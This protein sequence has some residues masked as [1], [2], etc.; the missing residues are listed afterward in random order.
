MLHNEVAD[1]GTDATNDIYFLT[2]NHTEPGPLQQWIV[3]PDPLTDEE[4]AN[5]LAEVEHAMR[6]RLRMID[7]IPL[8]MSKYRICMR[9]FNFRTSSTDE[10][11]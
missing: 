3:P 2:Y 6:Y 7:V 10:C 8:E 5:T 9:V 1:S 4:V 11:T